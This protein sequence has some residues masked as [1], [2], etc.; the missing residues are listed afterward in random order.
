MKTCNMIAVEMG[1]TWNWTVGTNLM[2][3]EKLTT[4]FS[5]VLSDKAA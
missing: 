2:L 1:D 4:K 3:E 5:E